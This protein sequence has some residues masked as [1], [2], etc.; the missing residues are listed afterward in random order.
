[1]KA[2]NNWRE[3]KNLKTG[4]RKNCLEEKDSHS[5]H[6]QRWWHVLTHGIIEWGKN[7][8]NT[9]RAS[10]IHKIFYIQR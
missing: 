2:G 9:K 1:M 5:E 8:K 10:S 6:S 3:K 7:L 4:K